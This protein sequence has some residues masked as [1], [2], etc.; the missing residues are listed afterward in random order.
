MS[1]DNTKGKVGRMTRLV[2][3]ITMALKKKTLC[4]PYTYTA[5]CDYA[6]IFARNHQILHLGG[7]LLFLL[8]YFYLI[9]DRLNFIERR[10]SDDL[11][12]AG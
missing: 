1:L 6:W 5:A 10:K 12:N 4:M 8:F 9:F 11:R 2:H 7:F 3:V